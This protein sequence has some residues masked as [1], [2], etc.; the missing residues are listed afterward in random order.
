MATTRCSPD[1]N[2]CRSQVKLNRLL[3]DPIL[4]QFLKSTSIQE[5]SSIQKIGGYGWISLPTTTVYGE[6]NNKSRLNV[7]NDFINFFAIKKY[8]SDESKIIYE[9]LNQSMR[10][11]KGSGRNIIFDNHGNFAYWNGE[12]NKILRNP[13]IPQP[14]AKTKEELTAG[15]K[16]QGETENTIASKF[17]NYI[18]GTNIYYYNKKMIANPKMT[19]IIL[20]RDEVPSENSIYY[21]VY[22]P[23][24]RKK[25]QEYYTHLLGYE[26]VWQGNKL[27]KPG[28]SRGYQSNDVPTI[29][30]A[31]GGSV[32]MAP[33]FMKTAVRYC[34]ALRIGGDSLP[35]GKRAEHYADPT[36]KFILSTDDANLSLITGKNFTQSNLVYDRYAP[37]NGTDSQGK[38]A[39][40]RN[41][42]NL[43]SGP[44]NSQIHWPCHD[45]W[46]KSQTTPV[47]YSQKLGLFGDNSESFINVLGNAYLNHYGTTLTNK[48]RALNVGGPHFN[49]SP[50]CTARNVNITSCTSVIEI[51][52]DASS[53][54][55]SMQNACGMQTE[56]TSQDDTFSGSG[57]SGSGMTGSGTSGSGMTG[58]GVTENDNT[59]LYIIISL[60]AFLIFSAGLYLI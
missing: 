4:G 31:N 18:H 21:L 46:D 36:C 22:N 57:T 1:Q 14:R 13:I 43:L 19:Y 32:V 58:S 30:S 44:G 2:K 56:E 15:K 38:A 9:A 50:G 49:E 5:N 27:V 47:E 60:L 28:N 11:G 40:E 12:I 17:S 42:R 16:G 39:F 3:R 41:K 23:I 10:S 26:G 7:K 24:H 34:N 29:S 6:N 55:I 37:T 45:S 59:R 54:E 33:S 35:N 52:G 25:F 20:T 8:N 48:N 53:N 51:A